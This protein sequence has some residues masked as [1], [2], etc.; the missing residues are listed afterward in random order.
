MCTIFVIGDGF[1]PPSLLIT[2][3]PRIIN[4]ILTTRLTYR[5]YHLLW[6]SPTFIL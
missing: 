2:H 5:D 1:E 6:Y 4:N 3:A